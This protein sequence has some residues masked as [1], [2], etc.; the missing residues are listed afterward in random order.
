MTVEHL[1]EQLKR[2]NPNSEV[3]VETRDETE[4]LYKIE[5]DIFSE[6]EGPPV[7]ILIGGEFPDE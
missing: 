3:Y 2:K 5:L 4:R 7:V 6:P 1:I